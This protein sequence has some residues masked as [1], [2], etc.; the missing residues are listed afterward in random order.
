M[1]A[2]SKN[3]Y[4]I[5]YS[6]RRRRRYAG[7]MILAHATIGHDN[8]AAPNA[9][10]TPKPVVLLADDSRL[11][12][13]KYGDL[14]KRNGFNVVTASDVYVSQLIRQ[15]KP[16]L[17][18]MDISFGSEVGPVAMQSLKKRGTAGGAPVVLF[19]SRAAGELKKIAED[20]GADGYIVKGADDEAFLREVK[21][22]LR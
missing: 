17:V 15:T 10:L 21:K 4:D 8:L 16:D 14:L 20:C 11:I 3:F 6:Y 1:P 12:L 22:Y 19:S 2:E 7:G 13:E 18:L 5:F 9:M